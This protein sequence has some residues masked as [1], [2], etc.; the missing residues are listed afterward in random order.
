M[1]F[2][3][4]VLKAFVGDKKKKDLK[5]LQPI[6]EKVRSFDSEMTN[7]SL[8]EL[9]DK[10]VFFKNKINESTKPFHDKIDDLKNE[11]VNANIDRK[12]EIY[13][14]ID[15]L[16]DDA[17]IASEEVLKDIQTICKQFS[18]KG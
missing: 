5:L 13:K 3:N 4:S 7:L 14:E 18:I 8:D 1:S 16:L 6:V 12:E 11:I 15:Q 17:Y 10:T 2:L 9:R